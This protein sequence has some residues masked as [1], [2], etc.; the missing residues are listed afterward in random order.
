MV[1]TSAIEG[2][3]LT[4]AGDEVLGTVTNVL[5]HPADARAI[6]VAVRP[7]NAMTVIERPGTYLPLSDLTFDP[8][9][10]RTGLGKLLS[11]A[12]AVAA[13]LGYDPDTTVIWTGMPVAD[14]AGTVIGSVSDVEFDELTGAVGS[15]HVGG[16]AIADLAHGRYLVPGEAVEGYRDGAV[17]ITAE[18]PGLDG[19]GGLA[20]TAAGAAV[21][22]GQALHA[23]GEAIVGAS[24]ATGCA[25]KAVADSEV[26]KRAT[27][28]AKRT[29]RESAKAF[30]DGMK[31]DK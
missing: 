13:A 2:L 14:A 26:T 15:V 28:R 29:W 10:A 19:S 22:A 16:G 6:G 9:G 18:V 5:F 12:K 21:A 25:I 17:R 31:D 30:R 4:G 24:G 23:A 3:A 11:G 8:G 1:S 20:K 7:P 27:D